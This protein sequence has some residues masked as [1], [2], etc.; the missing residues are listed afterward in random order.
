MGD[1]TLS[2]KAV[3]GH[4]C[5]REARE[6]ERIK[7]SLGCTCPDCLFASFVDKLR[8]SGN[9]IYH[10]TQVHW[11]DNEAITDDVLNGVRVKG[12]FKPPRG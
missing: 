6:G 11:P 4:G 7:Y 3:G 5:D 1:Y 2:I 9:S 12:S 8:E 10:A